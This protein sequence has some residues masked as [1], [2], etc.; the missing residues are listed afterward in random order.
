MTPH[1]A[2]RAHRSRRR[3]D[4]HL[5]RAGRRRSS[6]KRVKRRLLQAAR[7]AAGA[8]RGPGPLDGA[9]A[10]DDLAPARRSRS[11]PHRVEQ[12]LLGDGA[13]DALMEDVVAAAEPLLRRARRRGRRGPRAGLRP[14][15][16]R[17]DQRRAGQ[18]ARRRRAARGRTRR[19]RRPR[20]P[21]RDDGDRRR[22][23]TGP[24]STTRV[25]GAV[26]NRSPDAGP[27]TIET[28]RGAAG[29]ARPAAGR[30]RAVPRGAD[31]AA[32]VATSSRG[33]DVTVLNEGDPDRRVKERH[34]R[35]AGGAGHPAAAARR[36]GWSSCPGDRARGHPQR[37]PGG[38]ERH[39]PRRAAAHRRAS[40]PI[41]GSGSCAARPRPPGCPSC[42]PDETATRPR[43]PC[44]TSI[45]RSRSTTPSGPDW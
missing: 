19:R 11:P 28:I 15:L 13:L 45:P 42:S 41:R 12:A 24:A 7:P 4:R 2:R 6:A 44:T 40:S 25:V 5:P 8:R 9:G 27:E 32:C 34:R 22:G 21:G 26:V 1:P 37:L 31:L 38:D 35:R 14:G 30:S 36:V 16:L 18:G 43:R 29:P 33:L 23:P 10:T 17:P 3:P 20:A 39:P